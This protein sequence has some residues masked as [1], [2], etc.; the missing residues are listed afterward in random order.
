M[1]V[2]T[3]LLVPDAGSQPADQIGPPPSALFTKLK[4]L[5]C[6][7]MTMFGTRQPWPLPKLE[8]LVLPVAAI[9]D[10][11]QII[12]RPAYLPLLEHLQ[13]FWISG[14]HRN[15]APQGF[16]KVSIAA[17]AKGVK[18]LTIPFV[19]P[20]WLKAFQSL[21]TLNVTTL[22]ACDVVTMSRAPMQTLRVQL[23]FNLASGALELSGLSQLVKT[24]KTI[25]RL[26]LDV[27]GPEAH[28]VEQM[29]EE[30]EMTCALG[31]VSL[32]GNFTRFKR[33]K[34]EAIRFAK[35]HSKKLR[36]EYQAWQRWRGPCKSLTELVLDVFG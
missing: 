4:S 27:A 34:E 31:G 8:R 2:S 29:T 24:N 30:L 15:L 32:T 28:I 20:G 22:V 3:L 19:P 13:I 11:P 25:Q 23:N 18:T 1:P 10:M 17:V 21:D 5:D 35:A 16:A 36:K 12:L 7:Y 14:R 9:S 33:D 26:H 6:R